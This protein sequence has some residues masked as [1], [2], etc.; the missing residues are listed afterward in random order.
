M[1][2]T[3]LV[4]TA[5]LLELDSRHLVHPHHPFGT[6]AE[7]VFTRGEGIR[8]YDTD[9]KEY[10]DARS[11]MVS[12]NLGFGY[13]RI[14]NAIATQ[15]AEL[16]YAAVF[17]QFSH[18][19]AITAATRLAKLAPGNLEHV[20][21]TSGGSEAADLALSIARLYW[22][23]KGNAQ[24]R[25][26]ISRYN[27]YHGATSAAMSATG[28][29]SGGLDG[30]LPS[31]VNV[32][33]P[34][35]DNVQHHK[36]MSPEQYGQY[37][38]EQLR[39]TI[40]AEGPETISAFLAEAIVGAGGYVPPPPGYW[41]TVREICDEFD[42]L[43]IL[44][45]VMTGFYRTGTMFAAEHWNLTPDIM[46]IG[47]GMS[48]SYV[49]CGATLFTEHIGEVLQGANMPGFTHTAH[50]LAMAAI[51]AT[52][53]AYEHDGVVEQA[54]KASDYL[55]E[56]LEQEFL[57]LRQVSGFEGLGHL[58][59]IDIAD[60]QGIALQGDQLQRLVIGPALDVGLILR[61]RGARLAL[62]PPLVTTLDDARHIL[63]LLMEILEQLP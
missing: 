12:T 30:I 59:G 39:A 51:N 24:R 38:A 23:R 6:P 22:A 31:D 25:K 26:V 29:A 58:I 56:R 34:P 18:T 44:D 45:E 3:K 4:N 13:P 52:L 11:Q 63:D 53:D 47:K 10:L 61:G 9:G 42:I 19:S 5:E 1:Q 60:A 49:P 36:L 16:S 57:S 54:A 2:Q 50:P 32:F 28:M 46:T 17:Y 21:F 48:S 62:C 33:L 14:V 7:V 35:I 27:S 8:L 43:L 37:A 55:F 41:Q 15:A 20:L 40:L